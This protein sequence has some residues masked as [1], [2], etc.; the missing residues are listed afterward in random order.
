[1]CLGIRAVCAPGRVLWV[2][3]LIFLPGCDGT[4]V[5]DRSAQLRIVHAADVAAVDFYADFGLLAR[6]LV[7]GDVSPYRSLERGQ[8]LLEVRTFVDGVPTSFQNAVVLDADAAYTV[9]A[10]GSGGNIRFL[11]V[12]DDRADAATGEVRLRMIHAA[13]GADRIDIGV[14]PTAASSDREGIDVPTMSFG[15]QSAY[16]SVAAGAYNLTIDEVSGNADVVYDNILFEIERR[17]DIIIADQT[18]TPV[19]DLLLAIDD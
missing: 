16:F 12:A 15:E 5:A 8:R 13:G 4:R 2:V 9:I 18:A 10:T 11:L 7:F 17:Y 14:L 6:A 19:L 1:M 3:I